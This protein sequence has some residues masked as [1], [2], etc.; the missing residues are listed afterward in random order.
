MPLLESKHKK[1][2]RPFTPAYRRVESALREQISLGTWAPGAMIPGR[3][4]L[5]A[6]FGVDS[7]TIQ[8]AIRHLVDDGVLRSEGR[9]G[10]FVQSHPNAVSSGGKGT[11]DTL[12]DV[13]RQFVVGIV[14][15]LSPQ[16]SIES[17]TNDAWQLPFLHSLELELGH[18]AGITVN[19][20]N[21]HSSNSIHPGSSAFDAVRYLVN[22]GADA[23][24]VVG[25]SREDA[26]PILMEAN[27]HRVPI[28]LAL[29]D[30]A[31]NRMTPQLRYD[32]A[33][34]GYLA[35]DHLLK[36][37]Y[38]RLVFFSPYTA[39]WA[40]ERLA[41]IR[42]AIRRSGMKDDILY[43]SEC[44]RSLNAGKIDQENVAF[45]FG[46][47]L[48]SEEIDVRSASDWGIV[49]INDHAAYGLI[50]AALGRILNLGQDFGLISFDDRPRARDLGITS[51]RPPYDR[52]GTEAGKMI[53]Q[54]LSGAAIPMEVC[55][56][57]H[58]VARMSSRP[59]SA[60]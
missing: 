36:R 54:V 52:M 9:R 57:S 22:E 38:S 47:K 16:F 58:V 21:L 11:N 33:N 46:V 43:V 37:G 24:V 50:A 3:R 55:L 45:R 49:S 7:N 40:D 1:A 14:A 30:Y 4:D 59:V 18:E 56:Q 29:P 19:F 35:A 31:L 39:Q 60:L 44:D 2:P 48:L 41:G 28:I 26:D 13:K 53:R 27:S 25:M 5:A 17:P 32:N 8:Y 51:V 10:T 34:A 42:E 12:L 23:L 20:F 6:R 15:T